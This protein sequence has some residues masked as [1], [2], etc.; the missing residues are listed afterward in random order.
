MPQACLGAVP[1]STSFQHLDGYEAELH[2]L[3]QLSVNHPSQLDY[4]N[5]VHQALASAQP[6][7]KSPSLTSL[8]T[9]VVPMPTGTPI[10][11]TTNTPQGSLIQPL[12]DVILP[13]NFS[14]VPEKYNLWYINGKRREAKQSS[15]KARKYYTPGLTG[16]GKWVLDTVPPYKSGDTP[17]PPPSSVKPYTPH[18]NLS[19]VVASGPI[20]SVPQRR[21]HPRSAIQPNRTSRQPI[22]KF[23]GIPNRQAVPIL[24]S[25]PHSQLQSSGSS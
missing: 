3:N 20:T 12:D 11:S 18:D 1:K 16:N 22:Q 8:P 10:S 14:P 25:V 5:S 21:R 24:S 23:S 19:G 9:P 2:L 7:N 4:L 15:A 17:T 6:S 13:F